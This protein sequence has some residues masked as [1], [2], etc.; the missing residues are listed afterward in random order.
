MPTVQYRTHC[1]SQPSTYLRYTFD[2]LVSD[3]SYS[4]PLL[5]PSRLSMV[6]MTSRFWPS[7][8]DLSVDSSQESRDETGRS[9]D[10]ASASTSAG[11]TPPPPALPSLDGGD[12]HGH[13]D[14]DGDGDAAAAV[15]TLV[16]RSTN[17]APTT[18]VSTQHQSALLLL[19]V[20]EERCN[21]AAAKHLSALP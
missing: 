14:G 18:K 3:C 17:V 4:I 12:I 9:H 16:R 10:D 1:A 6:I 13:G 2:T 5:G 7:S 20:I 15:Q 19:S 11:P 8:E 21:T